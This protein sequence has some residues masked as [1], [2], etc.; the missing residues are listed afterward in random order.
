M[1]LNPSG[2]IVDYDTRV[3]N[4]DV[5]GSRQAG[6]ASIAT[7]EAALAATDARLLEPLTVEFMGDT[8]VQIHTYTHA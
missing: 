4:D 3:R 6:L 5:E 7:L 8:Q 2:H 1:L